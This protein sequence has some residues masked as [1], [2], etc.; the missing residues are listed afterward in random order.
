MHVSELPAAMKPVA[1]SSHI[2]LIADALRR[3]L[4]SESQFLFYEPVFGANRSGRLFS[5]RKSP[6]GI[7]LRFAPR[8][9][10]EELLRLT[11]EE[12]RYED[13]PAQSGPIAHKG[14][15]VVSL[16]IDGAPA[17]IA[18]AKWTAD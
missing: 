16:E 7:A 2:A 10:A 8:G 3:T 18:W 11:R 6:T 17:A 12:A 4:G 14:W 13:E 9:A 1:A 5:V 15:E